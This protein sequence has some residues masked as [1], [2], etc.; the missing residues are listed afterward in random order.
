MEATLELITQLIFFTKN[1]KTSENH[2]FLNVAP[3]LVILAPTIS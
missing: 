2:N 1:I 3:N